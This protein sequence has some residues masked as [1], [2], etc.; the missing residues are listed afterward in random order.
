VR[1]LPPRKKKPLGPRR[2]HRGGRCAGRGRKG[3]KKEIES[4]ERGKAFLLLVRGPLLQ[5][6]RRE[7][8][9]G[10]SGRRRGVPR[11]EGVAIHHLQKG[12]KKKRE[13]FCRA[14]LRDQ[15][16]KRKEWRRLQFFS[17]EGKKRAFGG[18]DQAQGTPLNPSPRVS[19][20]KRGRKE[21]SS[22]FSLQSTPPPR[23]EGEETP[24]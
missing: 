1:S 19:A 15:K 8:A 12:G 13:R 14:R 6:H 24:A 23:E 17:R 7:A 22:Q 3:R 18:G 10:T 4:L 5:S 11:G 21:R 2:I 16:K 20:K 9:C